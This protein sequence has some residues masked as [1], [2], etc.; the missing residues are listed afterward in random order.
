MTIDSLLF[1][2]CFLPVVLLLHWLIPGEGFRKYLLLAASLLFCAFGSLSGVL[3]LTAAAGVNYIFGRLI[4]SGK[5]PKAACA[6]AVALDLAFLCFFKYLDF[7]LTQVLGLPEA[8][9]GIAAPIGISFYIFKCI[10]YIVDVY[11][12]STQGTKNFGRFFLYVSFFPQLTAGPITRF[13]GFAAQMSGRKW[14]AEA[15]A[16][17]IRRF[18]LGLGKKLL[19][20]GTLAKAADGVFALTPAAVDMP[21]A[22]LGA[23]SYMLQIYFDFSGYSDMAIGLGAA[24]GF[25][26]PENFQYPY[27]AVSVTDFW[28][29]WHISLSS[30]FKDYLYIPLGGNRRGKLRTAVNKAA[31]FFFCGIWHGA[32]WTF[33]L[34]GLWH[35]LF[36]ALESAKLLRPKGGILGRIY[37]LL[38][39]CLG[40]VMFR[41]ATVTQGLQ[42]TVA[43]FAGGVST[44]GL[45]TL[46]SLL[47][48]EAVLSLALGAVFA[49]PVGSRLQKRLPESLGFVL[50]VLLFL[51]CLLKLASG[52]FAPFIYAQF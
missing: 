27:A 24:F 39:V 21:L 5:A 1:I 33:L 2:S 52:G 26:T 38:A 51:L 31:V 12:D 35:G 15:A 49:Q 32:N 29:R 43:M 36:S 40:F 19:L 25:S 46:R 42:L 4:L 34:W 48:G 18:I 37:T 11:R 17:G 16:R 30:W 8:A 20:A 3:L 28:R 9:L 41:A 7:L 23:V 22:W 45:E 6:A 50:A 14:D 10:S 47:T 44:M 13:P